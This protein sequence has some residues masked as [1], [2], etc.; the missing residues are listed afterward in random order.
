MIFD[1]I[2]SIVIFGVVVL[3]FLSLRI[4]KEYDRGVIFFLGK[5]T[6]IRGPGLIILIPVLEQMTKV[7]LRTITMNIPSQKIITK[8][9]VSIDIAAV[10]Y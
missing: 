4:V 5:V 2:F 10:A 7:T 1:N 9:N 6:G 3:L 8:D